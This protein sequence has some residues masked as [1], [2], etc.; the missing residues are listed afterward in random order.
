M[1]RQF[2]I[3]LLLKLIIKISNNNIRVL[4][5]QDYATK[6]LFYTPVNIDKSVEYGFDF[7]ANFNVAKDWSVY[8]L[9]SFYNIEDESDFRKHNCKSKSMVQL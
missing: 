3:I 5:I 6:I 1:E 8:F 7:S 2:Q 9:T 4:P